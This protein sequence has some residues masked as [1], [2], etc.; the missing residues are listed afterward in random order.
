M[1][2]AL[3]LLPADDIPA[4]IDYLFRFSN[5]G[6]GIRPFLNYLRNYWEPS[7]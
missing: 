2:K 6:Q 5:N 1:A 3:A 7:K 4:G